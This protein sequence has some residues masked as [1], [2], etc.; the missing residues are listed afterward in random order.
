MDRQTVDRDYHGKQIHRVRLPDTAPD[1]LGTDTMDRALWFDEDT[2]A[3]TVDGQQIR[4][5][6]E[7][8]PVE[9][10]EFAYTDDGNVDTI[11]STSGSI[12]AFAYTDD[13]NVETITSTDDTSPTAFT[14]TD[15]G[16]VHTITA[17]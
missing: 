5:A 7:R 11:T 9:G 16:D 2:I 17:A 6:H 4:L 3:F 15:A 13:G 10:V 1:T 14:Y 8:S 12:T